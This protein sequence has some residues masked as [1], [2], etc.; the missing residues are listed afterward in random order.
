MIGLYTS[1]LM[2]TIYGYKAWFEIT[3]KC[4]QN[5]EFM[6]VHFSIDLSYGDCILREKI[7][8]IP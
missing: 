3:E 8:R 5:Q 7:K 6:C 4:I 1:A 2:P